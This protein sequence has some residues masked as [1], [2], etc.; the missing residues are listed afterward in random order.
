MLSFFADSTPIIVVDG[1]KSAIDGEIGSTPIVVDGEKSAIVG[2]IGSTPIVAD[3]EK[4][5][6]EEMRSTPVQPVS[7]SVAVDSDKSEVEKPT[8][9][10]DSD[11]GGNAII[12]ESFCCCFSA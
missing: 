6:A 9:A 4:S 2:E 12:L 10:S 11:D 8:L 5:S 3:G 1:E 7:E